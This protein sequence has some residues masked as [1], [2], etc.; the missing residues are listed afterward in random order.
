MKRATSSPFKEWGGEGKP[1]HMQT[2]W[3]DNNLMTEAGEQ[4]LNKFETA[5][6]N[7]LIGNGL[8]YRS[9]RNPNNPTELIDHFASHTLHT[10]TNVDSY[11]LKI[12]GLSLLWRSAVT[13]HDTF[14]HININAN[15]ETELREAITG[16][17]VLKWNE[18]PV[19]F[20]FF[21]AKVELGKIAPIYEKS[22][23]AFRFFLDGVVCYVSKFRHNLWFN[24]LK[25]PIIAGF[26]KSTIEI[27]CLSSDESQHL[28]YEE[29]MATRLYNE[30]GD[31]FASKKR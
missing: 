15:V 14:K 6:A 5:A 3:I 2:G 21:E 10:F 31:I 28:K 12:F 18:Y 27:P 9:R 29:E 20:G 30:Q 19:Y 4:T 25:G 7:L 13:S 8:T 23:K 11:S 17:N 26:N 24:E 1:N 22:N 16:K